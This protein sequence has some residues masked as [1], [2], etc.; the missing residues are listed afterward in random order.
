MLS[1]DLMLTPSDTDRLITAGWTNTPFASTI[2]LLVLEDET[3]NRNDK[4]LILG[5]LEGKKTRQ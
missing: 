4:I 1:L 5:M 2:I 3:V